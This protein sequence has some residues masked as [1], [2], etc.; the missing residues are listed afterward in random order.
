MTKYNKQKLKH[1]VVAIL[2]K[3]KELEVQVN[4]KPILKRLEICYKIK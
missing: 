1:N 3:L 2:N 4:I